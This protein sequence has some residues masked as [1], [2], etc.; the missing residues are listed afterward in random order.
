MNSPRRRSL[1]PLAVLAAVALLVAAETLIVKVQTTALRSEPKFYAPVIVTLK[2]GARL[3]QVQAQGDWLKVKAVAGGQTGWVHKSAVEA[4][5]FSLMAAGGG[6]K[7]QAS[8]GEVALAAKG[9]NKQVEDSYKARHGGANFA[10]VDAM[11]KLKA[12]PAEVE[13]FVKNGKLG[14]TGGGR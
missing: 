3:T 4:K 9:F 14:E 5:K 13:A 11:L 12:A 2:A 7:T 1:V 6:A 10:A 8:A